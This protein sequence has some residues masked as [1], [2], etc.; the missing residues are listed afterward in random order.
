MSRLGSDQPQFPGDAPLSDDELEQI[1]T[2]SEPPQGD[3]TKR[4][5]LTG[6]EFIDSAQTDAPAVWGSG[7]E[8]LWSPGEP[9]LICG[10]DGSCKTTLAWRLVLARAGIGP[11][12]VLGFPVAP[13]D[14]PVLYI[15]ADRPKQ[16]ARCAARMVTAENTAAL[17]ERV[18]VHRGPLP[19]DVIREP[20]ELARWA[21]GFGTVFLDSLVAA[22][23]N[24]S[25]DETGSALS[26]AFAHLVTAEIEFVGLI[27]PRKAN[28]DNREPKRLEDVYGSR[29]IT[30]ASGSVLGLWAKT[31]GDPI[32]QVNHLKPPQDALAPFKI[33][34]DTATGQLAVHEGKDLLRFL[35]EAGGATVAEVAQYLYEAT[36]KSSET[37]ARRKLKACEA[38]GLAFYREGAEVPGRGSVRSPGRW[39]ATPPQ[40]YTEPLS[41]A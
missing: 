19:F 26:T 28:A 13:A 25:G 12:E 23:P 29:L 41:D 2:Q 38:R 14:K 35:R 20:D 17:A 18:R 30:A 5:L 10:P 21:F 4:T 36:D 24:L 16:I 22:V 32:I 7:S 27:H 8:V 9:F 31:A 1:L 40:G 39:F 34:H 6:A 15:A 33:E 3:G 37:R 11:A